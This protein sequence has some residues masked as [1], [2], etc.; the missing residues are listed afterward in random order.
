MRDSTKAKGKKI[1]VGE[2]RARSRSSF[3]SLAGTPPGR[4]GTSPSSTAGGE[5][6]CTRYRSSMGFAQYGIYEI[7]RLDIVHVLNRQHGLRQPQGFSA[8]S[9]ACVA[10]VDGEKGSLY[11]VR[12]KVRDS[13]KFNSTVLHAFSHEKRCSSG[14]SRAGRARPRRTAG[15]A[16]PRTRGGY[17]F[18]GSSFSLVHGTSL[19]SLSAFCSGGLLYLDLR[20]GQAEKCLVEKKSE[21]IFKVLAGF[22]A[23][24]KGKSTKRLF[25]NCGFSVKVRGVHL[26][27]PV[28]Q[29]HIAPVPAFRWEDGGKLLSEL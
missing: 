5:S 14:A 20:T 6:C 11:D 3:A 15:S 18:P 26:L 9:E 10:V 25:F 4:G 23:V 19:F 7:R 29:A 22:T 21:G 8:V 16:S 27:L 12:N 24:R 13:P 1:N 28:E 17:F 2:C